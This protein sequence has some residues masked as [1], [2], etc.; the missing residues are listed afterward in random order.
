MS[1]K[2]FYFFELP[3]TEE[4]INGG[5]CGQWSVVDTHIDSAKAQLQEAIK[6]NIPVIESSLK[7]L[8]FLGTRAGPMLKGNDG[9]IIF[10]RKVGSG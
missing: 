10:C 9:R 5:W 7:D 8:I 6:K 1:K 3:E 2:E 4:V